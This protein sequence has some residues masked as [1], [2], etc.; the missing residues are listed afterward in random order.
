M[1]TT[2]VMLTQDPRVSRRTLDFISR[3]VPPAPLSHF[4]LSPFL[5]EAKCHRIT[6]AQTESWTRRRSPSQSKRRIRSTEAK[7]RLGVATFSGADGRTG[8]GHVAVVDVVLAEKYAVVRNRPPLTTDVVVER[9]AAISRCLWSILCRRVN[10]VQSRSV[11]VRRERVVSG[12]ST[13]AER[14]R[15]PICAAAPAQ[16]KC[17]RP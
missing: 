17:R 9:G 11:V 10:L 8:S 4:V 12:R 15:P 3:P 13:K 14:R 7:R 2:V 16:S 6:F 5:S 1:K